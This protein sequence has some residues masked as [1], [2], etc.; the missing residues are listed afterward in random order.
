M[1]DVTELKVVVYRFPCLDVTVIIIG[2]YDIFDMIYL[3]HIIALEDEQTIPGFAYRDQVWADA[4]TTS[5]LLMQS[6]VELAQAEA[7]QDHTSLAAVRR[8]RM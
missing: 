6:I 8:L 1:V 2:R 5:V 3:K 7:Q 4:P